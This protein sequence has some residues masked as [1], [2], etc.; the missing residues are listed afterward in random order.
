VSEGVNMYVGSFVSQVITGLVCYVLSQCAV[1]CW[2]RG[3]GHSEYEFSVQ[4]VCVKIVVGEE[5]CRR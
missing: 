2:D 4:W 5:L 1:V 3:D